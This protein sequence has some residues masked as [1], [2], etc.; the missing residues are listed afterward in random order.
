MKIN[1][2]IL[3]VTWIYILLFVISAN[4]VNYSK[5]DPRLKLL[6]KNPDIVRLYRMQSTCGINKP[7]SPATIDVILKTRADANYLEGLG[8]KVHAQI[9]SI[10]TVNAPIEIL[11]TISANPMIEYIEAPQ[12]I[13]IHTDI[14]VP[15]VR[16]TS[17]YQI[18]E[19]RGHGVIIGIIDTG[20]DWQHHDFRNMDG[21]TRIKYLLDF[22]Y[23]GDIN[24]DDVL[25]GPDQFGGT[26]YTEQEINN[27]LFGTGTIL[28]ND[29]VGHGT[30]VAGIA[31]GNGRATGNGLPS[32]QY[33]GVAPE[34]D[35]IIVKATRTQGAQS[36]T[37]IDYVNALKFIDDM[38]ALT[39]QPYVVNMSLG[40]NDGAHDGTT[41][42]EQAIDELIGTGIPGKVVVV[43]A[44]NDGENDIH[45]SGTFSS[46]NNSYEIKFQ[47]DE[48]DSNTSSYDDYIIFEVWY[49]SATNVSVQLTDPDGISYGPISKGVEYSKNT[50]NGA[51]Y[52]DNA[53]SG[54]NPFNQ[55]YQALIQLFDYEILKPPAAGQWKIVLSG[56]SGR[57]DLWMASS[58]MMVSLTS[59]VDPN[60][61]IANPGSS[62]DVITVGS[63]VTK[64]RWQDLDGKTI[65]PYP[66]PELYTA[67]AFSS[68]GPTRDFRMKPDISAPGE[69]ITSSYSSFA[70][71]T[72]PY[73]M[74]NTGNASIPNGFITPDG[75]HALAQGTSFSSPF[76]SGIV[77]LFLEKFP[78]R[79][80]VEIKSA[81]INT[82]RT[83]AFTISM[84]KWGHGKLDGFNGMQ[85]LTGELSED[86]ISINIFQNPA[87]TQ[88]I[89]IYLITNSAL[90]I[91]PT[92]TLT[93]A[94]GQSNSITLTKL[95]P[96]IYKGDYKF[97][98][99]G[100]A[101][102]QVTTKFPG[103]SARTTTRYFGIDILKAGFGGTLDYEQVELNILDNPWQ[104]DVFFTFQPS[105]TAGDNTDISQIG[106]AYK[107]G[108]ES[109]R[110]PETISMTFHLDSAE[111]PVDKFNRLAIYRLTQ[112]TWNKLDSRIDDHHSGIVAQV[113]RLG[114]YGL[115]LAEES[116]ASPDNVPADYL[117]YKN[118]PNPF[119]AETT[120]KYQLANDSKITIAIYN[121]RGQKICILY[122]GLQIAGVHAVKWN[123]LD[124]N[125]VPVSS[126]IYLYK[127]ESHLFTASEKMLYLK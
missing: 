127:I 77:A 119:N 4:A 114:T 1:R 3:G 96:L 106:T 75:V 13:Q 33:T 94:N 73:T 11:K 93:E 61:L 20:I 79:D 39:K 27:A 64:N 7:V 51:V 9:G 14:A 120:I 54:R 91:T 97:T 56:T 84:N 29:V 88:Y 112:Q 34:A 12:L 121:I 15:E 67:S 86:D 8:L 62:F 103:E 82:A 28:S 24:G 50:A 21:T 81:I 18:Y 47:V 90:D 16:A 6:T 68:P 85:Y 89:D 76:V 26:L 124:Y 59:N 87:I 63:Y 36:F 95:E 104:S 100:T 80:A 98:V 32:G 10:V 102:L 118:Y 105:E 116:D 48:Y 55:D 17:I 25:D 43:S 123:G 101:T 83:D 38:A 99:R 35:L 109:L 122:D 23:P 78:D 40:G 74:Y 2:L 117:L 113:D 110:F 58:T 53:S 107:I 126:G 66:L 57:F 5:L 42:A 70:P 22:S 69:W 111:I 125:S 41:L 37:T 31:A 71:P 60:M 46:S 115:F 30:H 44:G 108:P 52:I 65:S 45:S 19:T 92:A 72:G 49:E